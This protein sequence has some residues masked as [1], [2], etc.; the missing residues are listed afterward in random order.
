MM[1]IMGNLLYM[2]LWGSM[3][4]LIVLAIRPLLKKKSNRIM[5]VLWLLVMFRFLCP[6]AVKVPMAWLNNFAATNATDSIVSKTSREKEYNTQTARDDHSRDVIG[7]SKQM[8]NVDLLGEMNTAN[9]ANP[10]N[11]KNQMSTVN[12]ID[13]VGSIESAYSVVPMETMNAVES[14]E[15]TKR[16]S[17]ISTADIIRI[18]GFIWLSGTIIILLA[19]IRKYLLIKRSLREAIYINEWENYPVK[20]SDVA[21]VPLAFG[22]WKREIYVPVSF[23]ETKNEEAKD[24]EDDTFTRRQKELILWH[25]TMHLKR[26]D[27]L[28]KVLAFI[29]VAVHWWNPL[30][31]ISVKLMDRDIE[32]ACD[33]AVL[34][35]VGQKE[36]K[37]YARTLLCFAT[38]QSGLTLITSFGES[39]AKSRVRNALEFRKSS[40]W[41]KALT[42]LP[43]LILGGCLAL[44]PT[45]SV[46]EEQENAEYI[47]DIEEN[48]ESLKENID[49]LEEAP[50]N[51]LNNTQVPEY[52]KTSD[53]D[54][55]YASEYV[56]ILNSY[57]EK[58]PEETLS[59][60]LIYFNDDEI[61]DLVIERH[62]EGETYRCGL[63]MYED[64]KVY[65]LMED[66][67]LYQDD[68]YEKKGMLFEYEY[69]DDDGDE[70]FD[71]T[72]DTYL[73]MNSEKK[74]DLV[75]V[76]TKWISEM[77]DDP[78]STYEQIWEEERNNREWEFNGNKISMEEAEKLL[79]AK[80]GSDDYD[81]NRMSACIYNRR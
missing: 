39:D 24:G 16:I 31:W 50:I 80:S 7:S 41:M 44:D 12:S 8:S 4:L 2:V 11:L 45:A 25:E 26:L 9:P 61:P 66:E 17:H 76:K 65:P 3:I 54:I 60:N 62:G 68:Y 42:M 38:K 29:M 23:E 10:E 73:L 19:G 63:Y 56:K 20:I 22:I 40:T 75:S 43:V 27:P 51:N 71:G 37:E 78:M 79:K 81:A 21:G 33:E 13:S 5:C 48:R 36:R 47:K 70:I 28:R 49:E 6:V 15:M 52:I 64:G 57:Q 1:Q 30:V 67:M 69:I 35:Q 46:V 77:R 53:T 58:Y 18:L 32:M 14:A 59:C 34:E 74:F 55:S 72:V